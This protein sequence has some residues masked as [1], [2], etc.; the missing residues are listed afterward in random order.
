MPPLRSARLQPLQLV[1][2]QRED[3]AMRAMA[4][5]Q[6]LAAEHEARLSELQ[7]YVQDYSNSASGANTPALISNRHAF[8]AKLREAENFQKT[9]LEQAKERCEAERTRWL[10]KRRDVGVLEQLAASYRTQE[11]QQIERIEQKDSDERAS[12]GYF[13]ALALNA[14]AGL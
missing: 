11:R 14:A 3:E 7:R 13:R 6:S 8:L 9:L 2:D 5:C 10:L 1:A 4:A 12:Q